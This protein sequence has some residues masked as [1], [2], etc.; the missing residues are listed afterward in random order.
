MEPGITLAV[1]RSVLAFRGSREP[2]ASCVTKDWRMTDAVD[3]VHVASAYGVWLGGF[4][5]RATTESPTASMI[6]VARCG[7]GSQQPATSTM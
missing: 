6:D 7:G 5:V 3:K 1:W 2:P 4:A